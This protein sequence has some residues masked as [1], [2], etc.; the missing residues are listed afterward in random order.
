MQKLAVKTAL[1]GGAAVAF[2]VG[3]VSTAKKPVWAPRLLVVGAVLTA[4]KL[5]WAPLV[6]CCGSGLDREFFQSQMASH[7]G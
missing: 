1:T 4:K 2:G 7:K 5:V 3:A 6:A